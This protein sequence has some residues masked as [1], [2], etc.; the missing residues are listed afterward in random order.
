MNGATE[1]YLF[2]PLLTTVLIIV[3]G[4]LQYSRYGWKVVLHPS[5]YFLATWLIS[6]VSFFLFLSA[7]LP[8]LIVEQEF[9][10]ELFIFLEATCVAFI[11]FGGWNAKKIK[12]SILN[13]ELK[14]PKELFNVLSVSFLLVNFIRFFLN[15]GN[16]AEVRMNDVMQAREF[17]LSGESLGVF[18]LAANLIL[19]LNLP[20]LIFSGYRLAK[21]YFVNK[22]KLDYFL[23]L[24]F[25]AEVFRTFSTGGRS[26]IITSALFWL[27]GFNLALFSQ[28]LRHGRVLFSLSKYGLI[29][30]FLF[31][32]YTTYVSTQRARFEGAEAGSSLYVNYLMEY[33]P[34]LKYVSGIFE[35]AVFHFQGYQYR[36]LENDPPELK[37][38]TQTFSF[39]LQYKVPIITQMLGYEL[40]L[41]NLL[42]LKKQ[43]TIASTIASEEDKKKDASIT[44]TVFL[45]LRNDFGFRGT[46]IAI[47]LFVFFTQLIYER[48]FIKKSNKGFFS[49]FVFVVVYWLW[50]QTFFNHHIIGSWLNG[51][52]YPFLIVQIIVVIFMPEKKPLQI[53]NKQ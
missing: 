39:L 51:Y 45:V 17:E 47:F 37:Y 43:S 4:L 22:S 40:S 26:G 1:V 9:L 53:S 41:Q 12:K 24:P 10:D 5:L 38:G 34:G 30:L 36:R 15:R 25:L 18:D 13:I 7:G 32:S 8:A 19:M 27:L 48:L 50:T 46:I 3:T 44:A 16:I 35:Y 2:H 11:V 52:L 6:V 42:G 33:Y 23:L 20:I 29:F 49:I 21:E 14:F 28:Q 31:G